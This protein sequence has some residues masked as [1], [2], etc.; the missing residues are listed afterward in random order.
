MTVEAEG[1][2]PENRAAVVTHWVASIRWSVMI[3]VTS[4]QLNRV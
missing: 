1:S 3:Y 4:P 2:A